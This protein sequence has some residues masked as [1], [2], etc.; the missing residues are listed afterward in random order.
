MQA[1][2]TAARIA[3]LETCLRAVKTMLALQ[4]NP[5]DTKELRAFIDECLDSDWR[6]LL[7]ESTGTLHESNGTK[8]RPGRPRKD[9]QIATP[10]A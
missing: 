6:H 5:D 4:Y 7:S 3:S 10:A 8:K 2:S 1:N 9:E